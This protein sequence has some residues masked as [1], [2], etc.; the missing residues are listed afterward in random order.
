VVPQPAQRPFMHMPPTPGHSVMLP[1]HTPV[2]PP[3]QQPLL[4]QVR[5][6]Q[7]AWPSAPQAWQMPTPPPTHAAPPLHVRFAQQGPPAVPQVWQR[8]FWVLQTKPAP[9]QTACWQQTWFWT[10]PQAE[11]V[12]LVQVPPVGVP[13]P[14]LRA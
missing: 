10:A 9:L 11:Q 14:L 1:A 3:V 12:P 2:P 6:A 5:L 8:S 7:Q 13:L 4:L